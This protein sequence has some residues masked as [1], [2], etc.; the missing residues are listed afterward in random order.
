MSLRNSEKGKKYFDRVQM[1]IPLYGD[2]L[3]DGQRLIFAR[4]CG[5]LMASGVALIPSIRLAMGSLTA[6]PLRIK[7]NN[8]EFEIKQGTR[9]SVAI[10]KMQFF[11]S[12]ALQ[13]IVLGEETGRLDQMLIEISN[14]Y[15]VSVQER[16]KKILALVE[17]LIIVF[18]GIFVAVIIMAILLG[19]LSVN[20]MVV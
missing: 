4:V 13:L 2:V 7:L 1:S 10:K 11:D 3:N 9:L 12:F 15:E 14:R 5:L 20:E 18:L 16:T 19:I 8:L 6:I 17:P